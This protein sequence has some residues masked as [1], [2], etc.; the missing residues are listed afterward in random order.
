MAMV[1]LAPAAEV[2]EEDSTTP[3]AF[4]RLQRMALMAPTAEAAAAPAS[5]YSTLT[6]QMELRR[7]ELHG[8]GFDP[9]GS[10]VGDE[11]RGYQL[12]EL[13]SEPG[14]Q[15]RKCKDI[16]LW[17]QTAVRITI[18]AGTRLLKKAAGAPDHTIPAFS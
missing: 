11:H 18:G 16:G 3:P 12:A 10:G 4:L 2:V 6:A 14:Q 13:R 7:R 8:A 17:Q 9:A 1:P 15:L 5:T